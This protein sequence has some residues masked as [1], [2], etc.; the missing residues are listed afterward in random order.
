MLRL[1]WEDF[2]A[3]GEYYSGITADDVPEIVSRATELD[4]TGLIADLT[5]TAMPVDYAKFLKPLGVVLEASEIPVER[6]LLGISG[7][8]SDAGFT[9]RQVYD[10]ETAQWI[11]IAPGD[12]IIAL[13]GVRVKGNNLSELLARYGE[14]DELLIHAFRDD[15]LLAW[16]VLLG[17]P[18][19][20][21][22]K[23]VIKPTKLGKD[24]LS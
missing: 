9:V 15:A 19:T 21:Q 14:G 5:Q 6:K 1:L 8:G 23:V 20:F 4:L 24:W 16:A 12:V 10:K 18:K 17:K 7:S 3:A 13:D 11:G 2:K 22:S